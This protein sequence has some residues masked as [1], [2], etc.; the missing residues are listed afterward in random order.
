MSNRSEDY[1]FSDMSINYRDAIENE[2][3]E[4]PSR[5]TWGYQ[6]LSKKARQIVKEFHYENKRLNE[7][8]QR[9]ISLEEKSPRKSPFKAIYHFIEYN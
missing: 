3:E 9:I 5:M 2:I 1:L 7:F 6:R 4:I 8:L